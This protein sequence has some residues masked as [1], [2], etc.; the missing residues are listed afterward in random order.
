MRVKFVGKGSPMTL[1]HGKIYE[2]M[3]VENDC[4]RI[5]DETN[6]DYLYHKSN[7]EIVER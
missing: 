1:I 6:E 4:Y 3:A 7:F 2:V 5:I